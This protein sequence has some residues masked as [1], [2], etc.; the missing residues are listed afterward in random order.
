M[1]KSSEIC[2]SSFE[3]L[4]ILNILNFFANEIT[5][6]ILGTYLWPL[7]VYIW[8]ISYVQTDLAKKSSTRGLESIEVRHHR[9]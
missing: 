7:S 3:I 8:F 2:I 9:V 4:P 5:V 1:F 6:A